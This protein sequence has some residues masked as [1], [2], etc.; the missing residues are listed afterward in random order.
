MEPSIKR[1]EDRD[2]ILKA[3]LDG[4]IDVVATDHAPHTVEEKCATT[5]RLLRRSIGTTPAAG[6]FRIRETRNDEGRRRRGPHQSCRSR[7]VPHRGPWLYTRRLL[8]RPRT[9]V[10]PDQAW[11]VRK[12]NILYKC[13]WS[14]FE[15]ERFSS[16]VTHTWVNGHLAYEQG[17]F[18]ETRKGQRLNFDR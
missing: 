6:T 10:D 4:R 7:P 5:F 17:R 15:G 16:R 18:D 3:V 9:F 14:P 12:E 8:G 1:A 11:T 13:G 2:A